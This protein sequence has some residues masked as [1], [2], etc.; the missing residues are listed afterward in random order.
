MKS[1]SERWC[2]ICDGWGHYTAEVFTGDADYIAEEQVECE[3]CDGSG[4]D[5]ED[6]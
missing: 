2:P 1:D 6:E 3:A 5:T 4:V